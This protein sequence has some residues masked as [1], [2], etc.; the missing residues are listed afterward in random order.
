M[1]GRTGEG[2]PLSAHDPPILATGDPRTVPLG[3]L[4]R[5]EGRVRGGRGDKA[6]LG[7]RCC[8]PVTPWPPLPLTLG[9][10][11]KRAQQN[12]TNSCR[13]PVVQPSPE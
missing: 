13:L 4:A 2:Q 5:S 6:L 3:S 12:K 8:D 11:R 7:T 1:W 10:V 9:L